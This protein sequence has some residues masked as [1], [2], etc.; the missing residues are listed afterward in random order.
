MTTHHSFPTPHR[1]LLLAGVL[2]LSAL[3][4]VQS[5][6]PHSGEATEE[7]QDREAK[8]LL[9][10]VW[11]N[12]DDG[13]P[14]LLVR[15]DSLFYAEANSLP[16]RV[17]VYQDSLYVQ[18]STLRR[19]RITKQAE[20]LLK[21][22]NVNGEEV[23]LTKGG[24][25]ASQSAFAQT[26]TYAMNLT[27]VVDEDTLA[28]LEGQPDVECR[29]HTEPASDRMAKAVYNDLGMEVD[30]MYLD[31]VGTVSLGRS[32]AEY[33]THSFRKA[34]F[35]SLVP[36]DFMSTA[37]LRELSYS[38]RTAT[39]VFVDAIIGIPDAETC[40]VVELKINDRGQLFKRLK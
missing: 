38:H 30:N 18:S 14:A 7:R 19:Y 29:L 32:G 22:N 25:T 12:A 5:C 2:G 24:A 4:A 40:Y 6:R 15:G 27:R 39:A 23:K 10:G 8:R 26:Q 1:R 37:I 20:H 31:N 33:Y 13:T 16:A 36:R 11:L 28:T 21:F 17:W 35:A 3:L 34:E 9:Q